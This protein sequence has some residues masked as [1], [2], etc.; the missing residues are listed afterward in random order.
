MPIL[1]TFSELVEIEN[2]T[3]TNQYVNT[4]GSFIQQDW[5]SERFNLSMGVRYD[6]Y[7]VK[8]LEISEESDGDLRNSAFVPRLN[9]LYKINSGIR[10]RAGYAKG[11]RAPQV[12]NEDLHIELIN[13]TRVQT[14]NSEDLKQE[15]SHAFTASLNS[16]FSIGNSPGF[17]LIEGFY[18]HLIDPFSDEFYDPDNNGNFVCLSVILNLNPS[19]QKRWKLNWDL[20]FRR[21]RMNHR[22]PGEKK[23]P[24][25]PQTLCELPINM[26]MRY[27]TGIPS[28]ISTPI[29]HLAIPGP[30]G[31]PTSNFQVRILRDRRN[32]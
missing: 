32:F 13:A 31:Y 5:K 9:L 27:S 28:S 21:V 10:I 16:D 23:K 11:Y 1:I 4:L 18:T 20:P 2:T 3:L 12:F 24:A 17:L 6:Y 14:I 25:S 26:G 8:D 30:C 29:Y 19:L 7:Q 22:K 15:T